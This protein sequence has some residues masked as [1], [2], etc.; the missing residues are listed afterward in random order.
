[1][2]NPPEAVSEENSRAL[3]ANN[4]KTQVTRPESND[5]TLR[6]ILVDTPADLETTAARI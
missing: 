1:M 2:V 3:S 5:R 6:A 4:R